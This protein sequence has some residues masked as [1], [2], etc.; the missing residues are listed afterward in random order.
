[1][2][3]YRSYWRIIVNKNCSFG[4][5]TNR[6]PRYKSNDIKTCFCFQLGDILVGLA[7]RYYCSSIIV[8]FSQRISIHITRASRS[9]LVSNFISSRVSY[10][11]QASGIRI[12]FRQTLPMFINALHV[13]TCGE[14]PS[15]HDPRISL[16]VNAQGCIELKW[17][18]ESNLALIR[19]DRPR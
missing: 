10:R 5:K 3:M 4:G 13:R 9:C 16:D 2:L 19:R 1:M 12:G 17:R 7:N 8:P 11:S 6:R 15:Y 14:R 18:S